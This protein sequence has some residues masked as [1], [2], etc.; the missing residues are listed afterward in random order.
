MC[1]SKLTRLIPLLFLLAIFPSVTWSQIEFT[2]PDSLQG[3]NFWGN[4][5]KFIGQKAANCPPLAPLIVIPE[6]GLVDATETYKIKMVLPEGGIPKLGG[7]S[8]SF[9]PNFGLNQITKIEY[10]DDFSGSD[11]VIRRRFVFSSR[12]VIF[13]KESKSPPAGTTATFTIHSIKNPTVAGNYQIAGLVFNRWFRVEA[14]PTLSEPFAIIPGPP[15]T[16]EIS[17]T[18]PLTLRAGNSQLFTATAFDRFHNEIH[19]L[20]VIW[21]LQPEPDSIGTV[22]GGNLFATKI[23][24]ARIVASLDDLKATSGLITVLPGDIDHFS[25]SQI[26]SSVQ[27]GIPFPNAVEVEAF[28]KFDNLKTDFNGEIFFTSSDQKAILTFN[29]SNR[30][31]FTIT[32]S[33]KHSFAGSNFILLTAGQQTITVTDGARS[34]QS[35]LITVISGPLASFSMAVQSNLPLRA[36]EPVTIQA[37]DVVDKFNN[38]VSGLIKI[39]LTSDGTSPGGFVPVLN[40]IV[41][42]NGNGAANQT[43]Y[44]AGMAVIRATSDTVTRELSLNI[45]PGDLGSIKPEIE[46]TQFVGHI[47][48]SPATLTVYDKYGNLKFD[49]DASETP[50]EL[51]LDRSGLNRTRLNLATDF[52]NGIA[53]L[54]QLRLIFT[55]EPGK[56]L[57]NLTGPAGVEAAQEIYFNGINFYPDPALPESVSAG[58]ALLVRLM[59]TNTGNLPTT[60]RGEIHGYFSSC[61]GGCERIFRLRILNPGQ[62]AGAGAELPT[63]LLVPGSTDTVVFDAITK[64]VFRNDTVI[65]NQTLSFPI[66]VVSAFIFTYV[67]KSLSPDTAVSPSIIPNLSLR[68]KSNRNLS[69]RDLMVGANLAIDFGDGNWTA[70]QISSERDSVLADTIVM[71]NL[72]RVN[73]PDLSEM[74][75]FT[76]GFKRLQLV[77]IISMMN[78]TFHSIDTLRGFDSM[79]VALRA[80]LTYINGSISPKVVAI[81]QSQ[82]FSF[83]LASSGV[84]NLI[85]DLSGSFFEL[86]SPNDN[87]VAKLTV[88]AVIAPGGNHFVTQSVTIPAALSNMTLDPRLV[89]SSHEL[90]SS[91]VDT[92]DFSDQISVSGQGQLKITST[93]L[94]AINPPFVDYGQNFSIKIKVQNL[95]GGV[96]QNVRTLITSE[97][98]HDTL[99]VGTIS[100]IAPFNF[101]E[102]S[103]GLTADSVSTPIK[104]FRSMISADG[105]TILPPDDDVAAITIQAPALI[106]LEALISG[107]YSDQHYLDFGQPFTI[108]VQFKNLGEAAATPGQISLSTGGY[109]FGI[110]DPSTL[111]LAV[112][113]TGVFSLVAPSITAL[114]NLIARI[115]AVPIDK[116][117]GQPA[118]LQISQVSIPVLIEPSAAEL[119]VFGTVNPAP[120]VI[121]G[122]VQELF[123]LDIKNST[124]NALNIV[125]LNTIDVHFNDNKGKAVAP[126][127]ILSTDE[128]GFFLGDQKMTTAQVIGNILRLSFAGFRLDPKAEKVIAFRAGFKDVIVQSGFSL[129]IENADIRAIFVSGPRMNLPVPVRGK[130]GDNFRV[131]GNFII[132]PRTLEQSLMIRNNPFNPDIEAA[133][134]AYNLE[135]SATVEMKIFTLTGEKVY[136]TSF[137]AGAAGGQAGPNYISW[138]GQN[139]SGQTVLNGVYVVVIRNTASGQSFKLKLAVMK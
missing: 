72:D 86:M 93:D 42:T 129:D 51:S 80:G 124:E 14:G 115:N 99:A 20:E 25:I 28:D 37:E 138:N 97:N 44:M 87:V 52:N 81:N 41:V 23:G 94:V 27:S 64:Y 96:I 108:S 16:L 116:N 53:D 103:L 10:S 90:Y 29:S 139:G 104:I 36:G 132:T 131:G 61:D 26:P 102:I 74:S 38:P 68:L 12:I 70:I 107:A 136:E 76:N 63:D 128:S 69:G 65:V 21:S 55:G 19:N 66:Q 3:T 22:S 73:I 71:L 106:N 121:E 126:D 127:L 117:T 82:S 67:P 35:G 75:E 119:L 122:T 9:P 40:D 100:A 118:H 39:T 17:P 59:I 54:A 89:M 92:I 62:K 34:T 123:T 43:L 111:T 85:P 47:F 57:L 56:S 46:P 101:E 11:L 31:Q 105:A 1:T 33:G 49:F 88:P 112:D 78:P 2:L 48:F 109:N 24:T 133:E 91:R 6:I 45:L 5:G 8:F 98:G 113:S 50:I 137:A 13:F 84:L 30:Y 130:F 4:D 77:T 135:M 134:I 110:P 7:V 79:Y 125:G 58:G 60:D 120:L 114:V 15:V 83:D 18:G 32:D 95:S